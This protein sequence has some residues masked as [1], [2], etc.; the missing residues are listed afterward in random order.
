MQS[1]LDVSSEALND[2]FD[3]SSG[4]EHR[5]F[6]NLKANLIKKLKVPV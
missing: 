4:K 5:T 6:P 3:K 2:A 1:R